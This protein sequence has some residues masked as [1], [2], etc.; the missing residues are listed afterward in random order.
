MKDLAVAERAV[1][2]APG[3]P[4]REEHSARG[5]SALAFILLHHHSGFDL[6]DPVIRA[7]PGKAGAGVASGR[8]SAATGSAATAEAASDAATSH[9][10]ASAATPAAAPETTA[11]TT[12]SDAA[13]AAASATCDSASGPT[14]GSV[15]V[16][17][18]DQQHREACRDDS[19]AALDSGGL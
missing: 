13:P 9:P 1:H 4:G 6:S 12:S 19:D 17:A 7:E 16:A 10:T 15:R 3:L 14:V 18:A 11:G 2:P 8:G 5:P